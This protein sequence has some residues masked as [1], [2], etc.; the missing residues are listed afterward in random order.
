MKHTS[1]PKPEQSIARCRVIFSATAL[2]SLWLD[3][4]LAVVPRWVALTGSSTGVEPRAFLALIGYFCYSVFVYHL[5]VHR[6]SAPPWLAAVTTWNDTLFAAAIALCTTGAGSPFYA[7]FIFAVLTAG[8][9]HGLRRTL[10]VTAIGVSVYLTMIAISSPNNMTIYLT[11]PAYLAIIGYLVGYL[12][13]RRLEL[14]AR[15]GEQEAGKERERIARDLHDGCVQTLAAVNLRLATCQDL[16]RQGRHAEAYTDL[17]VLQANVTGEY[18][19]LRAYMRSLAGVR[20]T[21][22]YRGWAANPRWS[23]KADFTGSGELV[24]QVLHI[25]REGM[26]NVRRHADAVSAAIRVGMDGPD[27]LITLDDDGV[28][29]RP[30]ARLPWSLTSRVSELGGVIRVAR[31]ERH[32]AHLAIEIPHG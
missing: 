28:G 3:P 4:T 16:L 10:I 11:R 9:H 12:G 6:A 31:D 32:G 20:T 14:E 5:L 24:E 13:Q 18:D 25:L 8:F 21:P 19:N 30:G 29:L 27:V 2:L 23:V 26:T 1:V 22:G 15:V 17:A 7:F